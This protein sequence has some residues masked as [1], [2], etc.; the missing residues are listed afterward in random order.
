MTN[1]EI[2]KKAIEETEKN[3]PDNSGDFIMAICEKDN[4]DNIRVAGSGDLNFSLSVIIGVF[5]SVLEKTEANVGLGAK[6]YIATETL[7]QLADIAGLK[8]SIS[9]TKEGDNDDTV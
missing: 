1:I 8:I 6:M 3:T 4:E 5:D 7:E 2:I 9:H